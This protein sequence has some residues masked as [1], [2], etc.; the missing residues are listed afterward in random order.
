LQVRL[1]AAIAE[2][3]GMPVRIRPHPAAPHAFTECANL[4]SQGLHID[5]PAN[6]PIDALRRC[7]GFLST[8]SS[9]AIE[10]LLLDRS[11]VLFPSFG[12]TSFPGYP[13]VASD[14][15]AAAYQLAAKKTE[16]RRSATEAFLCD[17]VGGR[18]FDH[19]ERA[20]ETLDAI[21]RLRR[22]GR[23]VD[24]LTAGETA[25]LRGLR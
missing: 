14:F 15:T 22:D 4:A 7:D 8:H 17:C 9:A 11:A 18:R 20:L 21:V 16:A 23:S 13:N 5:D 24:S 6:D 25:G 1:L 3:T 12:L 10:A 19:T 2:A